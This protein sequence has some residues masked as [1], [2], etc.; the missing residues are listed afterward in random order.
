MVELSFSDSTE[1]I[2]E[3]EMS[4]LSEQD[5]KWEDVICRLDPHNHLPKLAI[6]SLDSCCSESDCFHNVP[7]DVTLL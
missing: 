7:H 2:Y 3:T 1:L 6:D 5:Q 4:S